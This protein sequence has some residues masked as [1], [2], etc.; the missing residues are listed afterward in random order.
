MLHIYGV[1]LRLFQ[2]ARF[3]AEMVLI[4]FHEK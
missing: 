4:D 1:S 2:A 3:E